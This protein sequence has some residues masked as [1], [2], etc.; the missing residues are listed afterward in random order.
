MGMK[1][2]QQQRFRPSF[3]V[4][5]RRGEKRPRVELGLRVHDESRA[6]RTRVERWRLTLG[7]TLGRST[8]LPLARLRLRL[9]VGEVMLRL[10]HREVRQ[11]RVRR[12]RIRVPAVAGV[13]TGGSTGTEF[14]LLSVLRLSVGSCLRLSFRAGLLL[15]SRLSL[16]L[17]SPS[18]CL[19]LPEALHVL[20]VTDAG[21]AVRTRWGHRRLRVLR[22][23][24]MLYW[25]ARLNLGLGRRPG[26]LK[27]V[28]MVELWDRHRC[29]CRVP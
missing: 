17:K 27:G 10:L 7:L 1:K 25:A 24:L 21:S 11:M 23:S 6:R 29:R 15:C 20:V 9:P 16:G 28:K 14:V 2:E 4:Q 12:C 18:L 26:L 5:R 19:L 8:R 22:G 3:Q 13:G